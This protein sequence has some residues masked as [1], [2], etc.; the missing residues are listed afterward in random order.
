MYYFLKIIKHLINLL[1]YINISKYVV[2]KMLLNN[3][4]S[5][6]LIKYINRLPSHSITKQYLIHKK[7]KIKMTRKKNKI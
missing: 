3:K 2:Y 1:R 7:K 4:I 6:S 5:K